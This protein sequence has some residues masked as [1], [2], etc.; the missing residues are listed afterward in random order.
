MNPKLHF[1][2]PS[3]NLRQQHENYLCPIM[4]HIVLYKQCKKFLKT[5]V[6]LINYKLQLQKIIS[7][8]RT[9]QGK[10]VFFAHQ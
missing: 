8:R 1:E 5:Q 6:K 3:K 2:N 9:S 4:V 10:N 7:C